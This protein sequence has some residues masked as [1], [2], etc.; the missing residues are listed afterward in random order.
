MAR[1]L[2]YLTGSGVALTWGLSFMFTRGALEDLAPLH[3]L[4]LRF[5]VAALALAFLRA[6]GLV[7]ISL[8]RQHYY[9]LLPLAL[10]Q[11]V[12]YF[13]LET[14]GVLLTTSSYAGMMIATIPIFVAIF[15]ALFLEEYPNRLQLLFIAA[16]VAGVICIAVMGSLDVG[17]AGLAGTLLLLGA[18]VAAA[19]YNIISRRAADGHPPLRTTWVMMFY[20][21]VMFNLAALVQ[22][23]AT[24]DLGRYLS[25]L[26]EQWPAV[27]YLGVFS[28]VVAFFLYNYTL[29]RV[30]ATRASVFANLVTVVAIVAGVLVHGE[31]LAWYHIVG[32]AAI[33]AGVWGTNRFAPPGPPGPEARGNR[34]PGAAVSPVGASK[35]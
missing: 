31:I 20:G 29:S 28:S 32:T 30:T 14:T 9:Q 23:Y 4:A 2:P 21:A 18:V 35:S 26:R 7:K 22:H 10:V 25:P 13:S 3:L 16:S 12:I 33:L 5:A 6:S 1:F 24:G 27:V 11:P 8:Q 34:S 19:L 17:G 15:S